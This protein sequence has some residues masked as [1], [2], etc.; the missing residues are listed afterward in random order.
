VLRPSPGTYALVIAL[1]HSH[2]IEIG[3][4]GRFYFPAG[5]YLYLGS[6]LGAGGLAARIERHRRANKRLHWH[7]DYVLRHAAIVEV[8]FTEDAR[9]HECEWAQAARLMPGARLIVA[10]LG[11]SDCQC[12]AHLIACMARP[13][14]RDLA[15][16][17]G[18]PVSRWAVT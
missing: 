13:Q 4:R 18:S 17:V 11:A 6:A 14:R 15:R 16:L 10:R 12:P 7:I 8:W 1:D 9:R 5:F 3:R 2:T